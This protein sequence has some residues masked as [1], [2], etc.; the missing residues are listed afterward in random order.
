MP[1]SKDERSPRRVDVR[2]S[3]AE[4]QSEHPAKSVMSRRWEERRARVATPA[5]EHTP[6][7]F[8]T[9]TR[10]AES[11][12]AAESGERRAPAG[13]VAPA[14]MRSPQK[15]LLRVALFAC[16]VLLGLLYFGG[17]LR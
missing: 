16:A 6:S 11:V 5:P 1:S 14:W 10:R 12:T 9:V 17:F 4:R 7:G 8:R 3:S 13:F 2:A 15:A